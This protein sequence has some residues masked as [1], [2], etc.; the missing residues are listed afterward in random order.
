[1]MKEKTRKIRT[2]VYPVSLLFLY[3]E[4]LV[5]IQNAYGINPNNPKLPSQTPKTKVQADV[6]IVRT[7]AMGNAGRKDLDQNQTRNPPHLL[8]R[9]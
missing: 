3:L 8:Q 9:L 4:N 5:D 7:T 2:S 6:N 1:M